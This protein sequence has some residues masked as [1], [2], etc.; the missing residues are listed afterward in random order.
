ME[1]SC[2]TIRRS[3]MASFLLIVGSSWSSECPF[4]SHLSILDLR[5]LGHT[6]GLLTL[7]IGLATFFMMPPSP[8]HTKT[9]FRPN[10]WF[11]EREETIVVSRVLRDDPTKVCGK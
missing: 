11:T 7:A 2:S 3:G 1:V 9:W 8:T 6:R 4:V 5:R 10:G